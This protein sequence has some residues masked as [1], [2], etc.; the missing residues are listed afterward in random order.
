M[1]FRLGSQGDPC[2]RSHF[3]AT[4]PIRTSGPTLIVTF[5]F[6]TFR[7]L[8]P[9]VG[10]MSSLNCPDCSNENGQKS[11]NT[12]GPEDRRCETANVLQW[13]W[14]T[15]S[16]RSS[17]ARRASAPFPLS[18]ISFLSS[19]G[20]AESTPLSTPWCTLSSRFGKPLNSNASPR[21]CAK[22]KSSSSSGLLYMLANHRPQAL[23]NKVKTTFTKGRRRWWLPAG[24]G[25][26]RQ[27]A[28]CVGLV[29]MTTT[30]HVRKFKVV[31]T[32]IILRSW[33]Q[34]VKSQVFLNVFPVAQACTC[35]TAGKRLH[36]V[37]SRM[38][39]TMSCTST[40]HRE[41][42]VPEITCK[43]LLDHIRWFCVFGLRV[44]LRNY[45]NIIMQLDYSFAR[46]D[47]TVFA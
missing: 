4:Q 38:V 22:L 12:R 43:H 45:I 7:M 40:R 28:F 32:A 5:P 30:I 33:S 37:G 1:K 35:F 26:D 31:A 23:Q 25:D 18:K 17:E 46:S 24:R 41:M 13:R 34:A 44:R 29:S 15:S 42:P 39:T 47:G 9:T 20:I 16:F 21:T 36:L 19:R 10:I 3:N 14:R 11:I 8:N 27:Q 6:D 2:R